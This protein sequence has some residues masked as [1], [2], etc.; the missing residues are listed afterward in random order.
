LLDIIQRTIFNSKKY[1]IGKFEVIEIVVYNVY[2]FL[3]NYY[4]LRDQMVKYYNNNIWKAINKVLQGSQIIYL[5]RLRFRKDKI[6]KEIQ[7]ISQFVLKNGHI[8]RI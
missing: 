3:K 7:S 1:Q 2:A 6:L 8:F 4:F 5:I